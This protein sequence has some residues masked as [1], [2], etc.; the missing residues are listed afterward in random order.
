MP[1]YSAGS[2]AVAAGSATVTGA[3]TA[4]AANAR[5]GDAF[6]GPDGA[7]YE[8]TN[9]PGDTVLSINPP[10]IGPSVSGG[11]YLI[12]PLQGYNKESADRLRA[13]V[14][15]Y[16][17]ATDLIPQL[18]QGIADLDAA[19]LQIGGLS[20][21]VTAAQQ[22]ATDADADRLA[23]EAA[24]TS[25]DADRLAAEQAAT[26]A[27]ADR[28]AAEQAATDSAASASTASDAAA[29]AATALEIGAGWTPVMAVVADGDRTVLQVTDWTGGEANKPATGVYVGP[30]GFVATAAEATN[31]GGQGAVES[32]A[33]VL[34]D[35]N[36]NVDLSPADI[37]ALGETATAAD[38]SKLGGNAAAEFYRRANILGTVSQSG[39]VPTGA[40]F[41]TVNN[42]NGRALIFPDGTAICFKTL[43]ASYAGNSTFLDTGNGD[44]PINFASTNDMSVAQS[45]GTVPTG[46]SGSSVGY[47]RVDKSATS[48]RVYVYASV[49]AAGFSSGNTMEVR[50]VAMGKVAI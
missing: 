8:V 47:A 34:P 14:D 30:T 25:A 26:N 36:G 42:A 23:A 38:S 35:A 13:I 49:G 5:I 16:G 3:G 20:D 37:G 4:F 9:I 43:A 7:L 29:F 39:G 21:A 11:A 41:Q 46:V 45:V 17:P 32:V 33:G 6:I 22:S 19:L 1:W 31:I 48:V 40:A 2:V 44:W 18:Q 50:I 12:A 28:A 10:Y 27:A 24:A 15:A